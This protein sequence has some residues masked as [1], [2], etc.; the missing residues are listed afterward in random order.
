M[1]TINLEL[2]R[3]GL[4]SSGIV[5]TMYKSNLSNQNTYDIEGLKEVFLEALENQCGF[6]RSARRAGESM[7]ERIEILYDLKEDVYLFV[8]LEKTS[9]IKLLKLNITCDISHMW[10]N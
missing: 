10:V 4:T 8:L 6:V 1:D 7:N 5:E 3:R 9:K 2:V